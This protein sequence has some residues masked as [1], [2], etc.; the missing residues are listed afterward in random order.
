MQAIKGARNS[1]FWRIEEIKELR[2]LQMEN[3]IKCNIDSR[4]LL[5]LNIK[6]AASFRYER[7]TMANQ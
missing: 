7:F 1:S 4:N 3:V 6:N 5:Q 2:S